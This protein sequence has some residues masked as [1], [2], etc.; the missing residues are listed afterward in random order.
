MEVP[1]LL[2]KKI[3]LLAILC[4][5][6]VFVVF[7]Y[8]INP[9]RTS[10]TLTA[11]QP[12]SINSLC[13]A[14]NLSNNDPNF[15]KKVG[16]LIKYFGVKEDGFQCP[17]DFITTYKTRLALPALMLLFGQVGP[18]FFLLL[19]SIFIFFTIGYMYWGMTC[20]YA[21]KNWKNFL[22]VLLPFYSPHIAGHLGTLM[23]EG[24]AILSLLI[25]LK[26]AFHTKKYWGSKNLFWLIVFT[27]VALASRQIWPIISTILLMYSHEN[28]RESRRS[29]KHSLL[30][31]AAFV[32][33]LLSKIVESIASLMLV[34]YGE[35]DWKI[36]ILFESPKKAL[37]GLF[38]GVTDD[39]IHVWNFFDL[40]FVIF[41]LLL[42]GQIKQ[43][44]RISLMM[45]STCVTWGALTISFVYLADGSYG[46]NFRFLVFALFLAPVLLAQQERKIAN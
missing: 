39:F 26:I 5:Q 8:V 22:L 13:I 12:D 15:V 27:L 29:I 40:A 33:F 30:L 16:S 41:S 34:T 28:L 32:P 4:A 38:R 35:K 37:V 31:F 7:T 18:W 36:S 1:G 46:Q 6:I 45:F 2:N 19:P 43:M 11:F 21:V 42:L 9:G 14:S 3:L 17:E 23:S 20:R 24:P 10:L 44:N 25:L